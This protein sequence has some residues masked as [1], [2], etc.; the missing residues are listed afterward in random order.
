MFITTKKSILLFALSFLI[1][2]NSLSQCTVSAT[3]S[4]DTIC[5]GQSASLDAFTLNTNAIYT[6]NTSYEVSDSTIY[7][8]TIT[9]NQTTTYTVSITVPANVEL[10]PNG[11]FE[12][13]NTGFTSDYTYSTSGGINSGKYG[14]VTNPANQNGGWAANMTDH[15]SGSGNMMIV[16]GGAFTNVWATT[17]TVQPNTIYNFSAWAAS[18]G[19]GSSNINIAQLMFK[20]NGVLIG[21][22]Y[23]LGNPAEWGNFTAIWNSGSST[24][25]VIEIVDQQTNSAGN[26]FAIDDIS[27][28]EVCTASSSVTINVIDYVIPTFDQLG[29]FCQNDLAPV[30]PLNSTNF[31]QANGTW[32]GNIV[33]S[34]SGSNVFTFTPASPNDQ[35]FSTA[36]MNIT[37]NPIPDV[38]FIADTTRGCGPLLIHLI[39]TTP[40][41]SNCLWDLGNGLT[42]VENDVLTMYRDEGYYDIKLTV[43]IGT[44]CSSSLTKDDYIFVNHNPVAAFNTSLILSSIDNSIDFTNNSTGAVNYEWSFGDGTTSIAVNPSHQFESVNEIS[45]IQLVAISVDGCTDTTSS[46]IEL[47]ETLIYYVPNTFT[48]DGD[49]YNNTFQ[50]I[51]TSGFNPKDYQ[52]AIYNRWGEQLYSSSEFASGWDGISKGEMVQDGMYTWKI[53]FSLIGNDKS[54]IITGNVNLLR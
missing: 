43:V 44:G 38:T 54:Q 22:L 10:I 30:L 26:D 35:C 37:I 53:K 32:S 19:I 27:F 34:I 36:T 42:S 31:P 12:S 49:N 52:L 5:K 4:D 1:N 48:P 46:F 2:L 20:V 18:M 6:W 15:T 8:P 13:G 16:D 25:A 33:T 29:P 40:N 21:S 3:V 39:N 7:N 51:F 11:N 45:E 24:T 47:N 41:T 50:P 9:P 14:I 17:V 28:L 23:T